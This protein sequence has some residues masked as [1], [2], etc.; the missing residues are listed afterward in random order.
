[1][2]ET[3]TI[4]SPVITGPIKDGEKGWPFGTPVE[5]LLLRGYVVEEYF[6]EGVASSY[7][8]RSGTTPGLDGNWQTEPAETA[9][10]KTRLCIARPCDLTKFNGVLQVNWQN[11]TSNIDLGFPWGEEI[12]RGYAWAGVTTQKIGIDGVPGLSEGLAAWDPARY[13]TL[14]HPGDAFSYDIY[15]Q[16][17]RA[18]FGSLRA[19]S[20]EPL[21]GLQPRTVVAVGAS[22]SAMRLGSYINIAHQHDKF[23]DAFYLLV[24]WGL[25]PP[26][27]EISLQVQ[28]AS[29]PDGLRVASSQIS[30]RCDTPV[31]VLA[32]ECEALD[33]FPMR[34]ADSDYFRF[35]EIAGAAHADPA[36][37]I[38]ESAIKLRDTGSG[39]SA[40]PN[41]N[42]VQYS[43]IQDAGLR[44]V[45]RW[46]QNEALP[47]RFPPIEIETAQDGQFS[48][49]RDAN[50][51]ARGGLRLPEVDAATGI[52]KGKN[53]CDPYSALSG[54]SVLFSMDDLKRVHGT[55]D[56]FLCAWNKAVDD[57]VATDMMLPAQTEQ[58]RQRGALTWPEMEQ[59]QVEPGTRS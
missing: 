2:L 16:A 7:R 21:A 6:L 26:I 29:R 53:S 1:M 4:V 3:K 10:Y 14:H 42:A 40:V 58:I 25:C 19:D 38:V 12:F 20:V 28:F 11:V 5:D 33:N 47:P 48:I 50:G 17:A 18:L 45:V 49:V 34:Q 24:H 35:W 46:A 52:H 59:G 56:R 37:S 54:E 9:A 23:F 31:L 32:T 51:I 55:R 8:A 15:A 13:G 57:L 36:Y 43:Y 27:E 39:R 30:D 44:W 22:Q 41:A